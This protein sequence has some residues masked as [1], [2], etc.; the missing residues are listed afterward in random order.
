LLQNNLQNL[1]RAAHSGSFDLIN[2][3][4]LLWSLKMIQDTETSIDEMG[5]VDGVIVHPIPD[6][7]PLAFSRGLGM[8]HH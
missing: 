5:F 1:P 6:R 3:A 2:V 7:S 8:R 4:L